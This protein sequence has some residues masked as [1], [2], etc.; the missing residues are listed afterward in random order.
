[1]LDVKRW[2]TRPH[3]NP[4]TKDQTLVIKDAESAGEGHAP[5]ETSGIREHPAG[6]RLERQHVRVL[7][8]N[9]GQNV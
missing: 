2:T 4:I 6:E 3:K 7:A 8:K 1:M 5:D 9:L